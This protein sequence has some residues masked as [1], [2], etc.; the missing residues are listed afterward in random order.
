MYKRAVSDDLSK[1]NAQK[2]NN[3]A[4]VHFNVIYHINYV[5]LIAL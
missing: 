1:V 5:N 2:I 3:S 4:I